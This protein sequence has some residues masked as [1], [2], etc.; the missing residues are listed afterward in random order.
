[1]LWA[2]TA[3]IAMQQEEAEAELSARAVGDV[4]SVAQAVAMLR[5]EAAV[6]QRSMYKNHSQHRRAFFYQ[7]LQQV[8]RCLRDLKLKDVEAVAQDAQRVLEALHPAPG[9]HHIAW[10]ALSS[11]IKTDADA[12]LRRLVR[13]AQATAEVRCAMLSY[14]IDG[15][16]NEAY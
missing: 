4:Q 6:F 2:T 16:C 1:M 11:E 5:E 10:K 15:P 14:S 12:V 8:K 7:H 9:M 13:V 3:K